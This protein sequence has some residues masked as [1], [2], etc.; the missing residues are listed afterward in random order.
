MSLHKNE[1]LDTL[2]D[3]HNNLILYT[4]SLD[5]RS[6]IQELR[7]ELLILIPELNEELKVLVEAGNEKVAEVARRRLKEMQEPVTRTCSRDSKDLKRIL[8]KIFMMR[9]LSEGDLV[10]T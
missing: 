2:G 9:A 1:G 5:V 6:K 10:R 3:Y 4:L 8:K 7:E